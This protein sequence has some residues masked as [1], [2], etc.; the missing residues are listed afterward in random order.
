MHETRGPVASERNRLIQPVGDSDIESVR[1][2]EN[3]YELNDIEES[4]TLARR[5][6][7]G[8]H[9]GDI[10]TFH[11]DLGSGKTFF[12]REIIRFYCGNN[13]IV[14]SPTFNILQIYKT[15]GFSIYHYDLYRLNSPSDLYEL[16]FEEALGNNICLIEWPEMAASFLPQGI[17]VYLEIKND[18]RVCRIRHMLL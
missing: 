14:P 5:I 16:G 4:K 8:L 11:G 10:V 1:M 7:A 18:I 13:T 12:A 17:E 9:K 2:Q 6:A 15:D 3:I